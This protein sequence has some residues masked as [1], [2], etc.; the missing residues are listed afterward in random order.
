M[1]ARGALQLSE[2]DNVAT[3]LE[4]AAPGTGVLIRL[5]KETSTVKAGE[6]IP[7]G[8]K[9]A[10]T[11]IAKGAAIIKYGETIGIASCDIKKGEMVHI[12]NLEGGRGRG[13]LMK[14]EVK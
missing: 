8:F 13:D 6:S 14:G 9:I 10:L 5:G 7:F 4:D 12:H 3:L 2:K 1:T 11:D